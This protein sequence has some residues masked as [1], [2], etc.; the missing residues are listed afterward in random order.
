MLQEGPTVLAGRYRVVERLGR[1]GMADVYR[2]EDGVL[3]RNVAVKIFR[4]GL[5]RDAHLARFR[6]EI[7]TLARLTHPNLVALYDAGGEVTEPWCAMEYVN[8]GSLADRAAPLSDAE[9]AGF[10]EQVAAA[11]AYVHGRGIVH[12]D[13]KPSNVLLDLEGGAFLSDFGIARLVDGTRMTQSGLM[14]GTA[15]FL[16]PEQVRGEPAGPAADVYALGLVLLE[17]L[18]GHRE[19]P[20]TAV[21]SAV[22]RLSRPPVVPSVLGADWAELLTGMTAADAE[23]RPSADTVR[24]RLAGVARQAAAQTSETT[25]IARGRA[26]PVQVPTAPMPVARG[27]ADVAGRDAVE[28]VAVEPAALS[29]PAT[30]VEP[31]VAQ[32]VAAGFRQRAARA[33]VRPV[34]LFGWVPPGN[35]RTLA[36]LLAGGG[37]ATAVIAVL[38]MLDGRLDRPGASVDSSSGLG[39]PAGMIGSPSPGLPPI[40]GLDRVYHREAVVVPVTPTAA[41]GGGATRHAVRPTT[42]STSASTSAPSITAAGPSRSPSP[43]LTPSTTLTPSPTGGV[44]SPS[45]SPAPSGSPT[46]SAGSPPP[47]DGS[48]TPSVRTVSLG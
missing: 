30:P 18:T 42:S 44:P 48:P 8:G 4:G 28:P 35:R 5:E 11:L 31:E 45:V 29:E 38:P 16:S 33:Q 2:A 17:G 21:E 15:A 37:V 36:A 26:T 39:G 3:G 40:G 43:T 19:Y 20:G 47:G 24:E 10:G 27:T 22:A 6:A 25:W 41:A 13:V 32:P 46:G 7:R 1:G 23:A 9:L 34:N 14:I 12:R